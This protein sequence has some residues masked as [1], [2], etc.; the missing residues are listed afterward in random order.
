MATQKQRAAARR[1]IKKAQAVW[2]SMSTAQR[3]RAQPEGPE[4]K[5][6]GTGGEGRFYRIVVRPKKEFKTF[7]IQDVG[8]RGHLERLAGKRSN[9]RWDTQAWLIEKKAAHMNSKGELVIDEPRV[10]TALKQIQGPIRHQRGDIFTASPRK[11][12]SSRHS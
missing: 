7:R 8:E 10:K 11:R 3:R 1:N 9:G 2:R 6:P 4:R 5:R 12:A